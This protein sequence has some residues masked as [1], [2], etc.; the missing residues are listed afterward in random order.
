[1]SVR[2]ERLKVVRLTCL[3]VCA[4]ASCAVAARAQTQRDDVQMRGGVRVVNPARTDDYAAENNAADAAKQLTDRDPAIRQ[5]GAETL[6]RLAAT[7][8]RHLVEGYRLQEKNARVRLA[9]DWALYRMGK[10]EPLYAVVTALESSRADQAAGYLAQLETPQTLYP[11]L[12]RVNGNTQIKLLQVLARIGN[13]ATL[14]EIKPYTASFDPKVAEA[15]KAAEQAIQ[16]RSGQPADDAVT[17][18]RQVGKRKPG[19]P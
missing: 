13:A 6:A 11:L 8:W 5:R 17:R 1:M 16:Q 15:A 10:E 2:V 3:L 7:E 12:P 18:P 14:E 9:L 19:Q 4:S